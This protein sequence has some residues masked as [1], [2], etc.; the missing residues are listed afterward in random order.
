MIKFEEHEGKLFRMLD[1][2]VPLTKDAKMPC[3]IRLIQDDSPMG[4][5]NMLLNR[6]TRFLDMT[7]TAISVGYYS[8]ESATHELPTCCHAV[9]EIIGYP[10]ADGSEE[11]ALYQMI[12]GETVC[13]KNSRTKRHYD[14]GYVRCP[15]RDNLE[16]FLTA[17]EFLKYF[18][19]TMD[20]QI[21]KEPEP[22]SQYK[23]GDWVDC[24]DPVGVPAQCK[25]LE[26]QEHNVIVECK[27]GHIWSLPHNNITRKLS[28]SEIIVNIGCMSGTVKDLSYV[29][30]GRF[31]FIGKKTERCPGGMHAILYGEMLDT[32]TR[33]LVDS[34][35]KAQEEE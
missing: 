16:H 7:Y 33:S 11:W 14:A 35:L 32:P 1:K 4:R 5:A 24:K 3:L 28:P 17:D 21:Y 34:L 9:Y 26:I 23:V 19:G 30:D 2:P 12:Q 8:V 18:D 13:Q 22:E 20:W 31:W 15:Y 10:V 27:T 29:E 25:V 6:T